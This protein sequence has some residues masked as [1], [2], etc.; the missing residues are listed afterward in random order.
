MTPEVVNVLMGGMSLVV[1]VIAAWTAWK[2]YRLGQRATQ[3]DIRP[4]LVLT[5][6]TPGGMS[7]SNDRGQFLIRSIRNVGAGHANQVRVSVPDEDHPR[8]EMVTARVEFLAPGELRNYE[9]SYPMVIFYPVQGEAVADGVFVVGFSL[10]VECSD[11][12][13][14]K[15]IVEYKYRV[16]AGDRQRPPL[17]PSDDEVIPGVLLSSRTHTIRTVEQLARE[18]MGLIWT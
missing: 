6:E 14:N 12:L 15:H 7:W 9:R 4:E 2:T 11:N 13:G 1:T 16:Y 3:E 18:A 10:L 8:A 5:L 17:F